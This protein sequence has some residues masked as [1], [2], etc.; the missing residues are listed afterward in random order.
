MAGKKGTSDTRQQQ[1]V[2]VFKLVK[3]GCSAG[4]RAKTSGD[5]KETM[6]KL[7]G[8]RCYRIAGTVS[9]ANYLQ[10]PGDPKSD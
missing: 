3:L 5:V 7:I 2:S 1:F 4:E 6:D 10:I 9:T 8:K